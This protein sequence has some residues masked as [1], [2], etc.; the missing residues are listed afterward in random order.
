MQKTAVGN[1]AARN[2]FVAKITHNPLITPDWLEANPD[3]LAVQDLLDVIYGWAETRKR[4]REELAQRLDDLKS[5]RG[6]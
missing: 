6:R 2:E 5:F 1:R 3:K 4:K